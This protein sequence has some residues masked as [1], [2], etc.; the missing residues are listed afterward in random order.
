MRGRLTDSLLLGL[1]LRLVMILLLVLA[2][3]V[4]VVDRTLEQAG[5]RA[6]DELLRRQSAELLAGLVFRGGGVRVELPNDVAAAYFRRDNGY[7]YSVYDDK[8]KVLAESNPMAATWLAPSMALYPTVA[9]LMDTRERDGA[10]RALYMLVQ[11]VDTPRNNKIY[12]V[13]GQYRT[14]DDVLMNAARVALMRDLLLLVGPLFLLAVL[15]V[16]G[17]TRGALAPLRALSR[18]VAAVGSKLRMDGVARIEGRNVPREVRPVVN[19]FNDV[20]VELGRSLSAQQA[21][22]ADTAHQLKTPLA[23]M[24]A[25]LEQLADFKGKA[26]V[27][28]DVQRMDRLVRQLL[29]FAV[30]SQNNAQLKVT[31][32]TPVVRDVVGG[33]VPLARK[34]RVEL[35]FDAP[36]RAVNVWLD[37]LQVGEAIVNLID[38]AIRHSPKDS[39]VE[40]VVTKIGSLEVRDRGPGI[41]PHEQGLVFHRFWQGPAGETSKSGSGL[42][43]ALVAEIMRQ[44]GGNAT[45]SSRNGGGSVFELEFRRG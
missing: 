7:V 13:V 18:E 20:L 16:M 12:V 10:E 21:L 37:E 33:M 2:G 4:W 5:D 44:H 43:L 40:V 41:P 26:D 6:Q 25:R 14:I 17:L 19:A 1:V 29:H 27:L 11:P 23:V 9:T 42:G 28:R 39:I 35:R 45:V 32:L 36:E 8:G 31:D 22:T 24:Q 3:V 15:A 30:L 34:Q 38:N